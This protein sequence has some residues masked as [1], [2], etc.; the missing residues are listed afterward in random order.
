MA[1]LWGQ[2]EKEQNL[3]LV[4]N[5][6]LGQ[7]KFNLVLVITT[8]IPVYV[9]SVQELQGT[10]ELHR[11]SW[12]CLGSFL[13]IPF[14]KNMVA[15]Q[16][17][18]YYRKTFHY[19]KCFQSFG[20]VGDKNTERNPKIQP[21]QARN[22]HDLSWLIHTPKMRYF[23]VVHLKIFVAPLIFWWKALNR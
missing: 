23:L 9:S 19:F 3:S 17:Q 12:R 11:Q 5:A 20:I 8:Q 7:L 10:S 21:I 14:P 2:G 15:F 13:I 1:Y 6:S 18:K 4:D 16:K 22:A